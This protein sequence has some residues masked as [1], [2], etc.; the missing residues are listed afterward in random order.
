MGGLWP[1]LYPHYNFI[2]RKRE[3]SC[4]MDLHATIT[5]LLQQSVYWQRLWTTIFGGLNQEHTNPILWSHA[6][7]SRL[8][9][10]TWMQQR[11]FPPKN[12]QYTMQNRCVA[13]ALYHFL[14]TCCGKLSPK[15]IEIPTITLNGWHNSFKFGGL[16]HGAYHNLD[17]YEPIVQ[18]SSL[19]SLGEIPMS[20]Q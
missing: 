5:L 1:W 13:I 11:I 10:G 6:S 9:K 15:T 2:Q 14:F 20:W 19:G 12:Y 8:T 17:H 18:V 4:F 3:E 7:K 16:W